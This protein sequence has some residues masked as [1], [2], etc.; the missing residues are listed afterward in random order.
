[1]DK[2]TTPT[3]TEATFETPSFGS[4][5]AQ[6]RSKGGE[7]SPA[8]EAAPIETE[9][10]EAPVTEAPAEP[11]QVAAV[12]TPEVPAKAETPVADPALV[13]GA[14]GDRTM[15]PV[16]A[17]KAEREKR[18]IAEALLAEREATVPQVQEAPAF[19]EAEPANPQ[20][21]ALEDRFLNLS[22]TA[23]KRA[24]PEDFDPAYAAF[25]E[26]SNSNPELA[27]IVVGS[28]DPG[29][30]AYSVGKNLLLQKKYGLKSLGDMEGFRAA[31]EKEAREDERK[32][33]TAEFQANLTAK[34]AQ[35]S[36]TPT[37]ITQGRAAGGSTETEFVQPSF[38][39][40]LR[41]VF[42]KR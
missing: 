6:S 33:V 38:A 29:E 26:A 28:E 7:T 30:A 41:A 11:A 14:D 24:H 1:M 3:T 35:R 37:D 21:R 16:K 8:V 31:V 32:K 13:E 19:D 9:T 12:A 18:Q 4:A 25:V 2:E 22:Q 20:V 42:P 40:H 39:G 15:V 27:R 17:L 10:P 23:A 36:K 5:L 34:A